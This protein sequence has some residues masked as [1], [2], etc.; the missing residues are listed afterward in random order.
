M[1]YAEDSNE[2][3]WAA[4]L[5]C[6]PPWDRRTVMRFELEWHDLWCSGEWNWADLQHA[7]KDA[8]GELVLQ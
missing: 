2:M 3:V 8:R 5:A 6:L 4:W 1:T 7:I